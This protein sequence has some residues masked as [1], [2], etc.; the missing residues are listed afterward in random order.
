MSR[1]IVLVNDVPDIITD[2]QCRRTAA[3]AAMHLRGFCDDRGLQVPFV[4]YYAKGESTPPG[5]WVL[6][7]V[8]MPPSGDEGDEAYHTE[9]GGRPDGMCFAGYLLKRGMNINDVEEAMGHEILELLANPHVNRV[10]RASL[11]VNNVARVGI[12]LEVCDPMQGHPV[13]YQV[14]GFTVRMPGYV[15]E[16]WEDPQDTSGVYSYPAVL[17]APLT[18]AAGGYANYLNADGTEESVFGEKFPEALRELKTKHS[19][20][21]RARFR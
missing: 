3:A 20:K 13:E 5:A 15:L 7:F 10:L 14:D 18:V 8:D 19:R 17:T 2:D 4:S 9:E 11:V 21:Q 12:D 16:A 1:E 6:R